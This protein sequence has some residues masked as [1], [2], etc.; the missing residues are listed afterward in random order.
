LREQEAVRAAVLQRVSHERN[1]LDEEERRAGERRKELDQ[2]IA[3]I[4]SD[5]QREQ[6]L[7]NDTDRVLGRLA[8]EGETLRAGQGSDDDIRAEAA[9]ALQ[10]AADALARA[11]EAADE[12]AARLS[13]LSARRNAIL[14][15]IDEHKNRVSRLDR[16]LAETTAKRNELLARYNVEGDGDKLTG[17]VEHAVEQA[18]E[19]EF[20]VSEAEAAV[21]AARGAESD[22]RATHDDARRKADRLQTE[23][24]TLTNLLKA[25]GGDLWPSLI[26]QISVETGFETALGAALGD[27]LDASG[28]EGAPV[29][30]RGLPPLAD[31]ATLPDGA[32]PLINFVLAP[33]ALQ[34]RLSHIGVVSK[35]LGQA[36]QPQLKPGQR[37]VSREGDVWRWDGFTAAADAP[38]AAA[39][40][41]DCDEFHGRLVAG[42]GAGFDFQAQP[43]RLR[44]VRQVQTCRPRRRMPGRKQIILQAFGIGTVARTH[45]RFGI[46]RRFA[47]MQAATAIG[48]GPGTTA[49]ASFGGPGFQGVRPRPSS[50]GRAHFGQS[51]P[52]G[53]IWRHQI[54]ASTGNTAIS[55]MSPQPGC[56]SPPCHHATA[57]RIASISNTM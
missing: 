16:E 39:N 28:D 10:T 7:L 13:E 55:A 14:R 36:L 38:S 1:V 45:Q 52:K 30:W 54:Q 34:R 51:R 33:P 9:V 47:S 2:R 24:R 27:D 46:G 49:G 4:N 11:Q 40:A 3:Q 32:E 12:A 18:A 48:I 25:G 42:F 43:L 44:T 26:D 37:L 20:H 29:H 35:A 17:A 8:E 19:F 15:A 31:T 41:A 23:V 50:G 5:L 21:R 22:A 6:E 56:V 57:A 53:E